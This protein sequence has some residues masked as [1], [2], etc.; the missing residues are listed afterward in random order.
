MAVVVAS[1]TLVVASCSAAPDPQP[2]PEPLAVYSRTGYGMDA[3]LEGTLRVVD[4]CVVVGSG[5]SPT[6]IPMFPSDDAAWDAETDELIWKGERYGDGDPISLGGGSVGTEGI[7]GSYL[8]EACK[9]D[10]IFL[11]SPF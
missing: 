8:P 2:E 10:E 5:E 7:E 4:G 6:T 9:G 3:L 11:V 1:L